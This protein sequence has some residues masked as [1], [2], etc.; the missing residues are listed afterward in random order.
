MGVHVYVHVPFCIAKC[1]YCAFASIAEQN[2]PEERYV[3][4]VLAEAHGRAS[5]METGQP[6]ETLYFGGGTPTLLSPMAIGTMVER[7]HARSCLSDKAEIS[8]EANPETITAEY[9]KALHAIGITRVS[10]GVQSFSNRLLKY[11]GRIHTSEKATRAYDY[12]RAAGFDNMNMDIIYAIPSETCSELEKDLDTLKQLEPDHVSAYLFQ[13]EAPYFEKVA[14]C[15]EE[16]IERFFYA[17]IVSLEGCGLFQYEISNFARPD[18]QCAHNMAYWA[19]RPYLGLGAAAVSCLREGLRAHNTPDPHAF[20]ERIENGRS[21]V[22]SIDRLSET[23]IAFEKKFLSLRTK[24]GI[25]A[26]DL[27]QDIPPDLYTIIDGRAVLTPK[28]MLLSDEIFVWL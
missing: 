5:E 14:P 20:M 11:L 24:R 6:I 1:R 28:G 26:C 22:G 3:S 27:P 17:V 15:Q 2:I 18:R 13:H 25:L 4:A 9:A 16:L 12:L 10:L 19:Y 23:D 21:P 7:L 8:I